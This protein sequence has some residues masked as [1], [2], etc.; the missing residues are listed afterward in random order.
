MSP[1]DPR[2][3][4]CPNINTKYMKY[5]AAGETGFHWKLT[6]TS[7]INQLIKPVTKLGCL[8]ETPWASWW[9]KWLLWVFKSWPLQEIHLHIPKSKVD[10]ANPAWATDP[11]SVLQPVL[12]LSEF[13]AICFT[14]PT[15]RQGCNSHIHIYSAGD[16]PRVPRGLR[17]KQEE[18]PSSKWLVEAPLC[19]RLLAGRTGSWNSHMNISQTYKKKKTSREK[20]FQGWENM[21]VTCSRGCWIMQKRS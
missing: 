9:L 2:R 21:T 8:M 4:S 20:S 6:I 19:E 5:L 17:M 18:K 3:T 1:V 13:A 16:S 11:S 14:K 15:I 7:L 10:Q 12:I